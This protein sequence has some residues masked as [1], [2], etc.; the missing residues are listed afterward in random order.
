MADEFDDIAPVNTE[1]TKKERFIDFE[2]ESE[3]TEEGGI[4]R[5]P[6]PKGKELLGII[7]KLLGSARMYVRCVDGKQ[8]IGRV[9]GSNK[10]KLYIKQGDLVIIKPW[11]YEEDTKCDVIYKYRRGQVDWLRN[12]GYL[13]KLEEE[14]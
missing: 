10:R 13:K 4:I 7:D 5:V 8:R 11:D 9:S 1:P 6:L 14:F 12:R 3:E 2:E